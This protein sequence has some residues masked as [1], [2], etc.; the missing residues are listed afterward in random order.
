MIAMLFG[1]RGIARFKLARQLSLKLGWLLLLYSF[2]PLSILPAKE[3]DGTWHT[4]GSAVLGSQPTEAGTVIATVTFPGSAQLY[5]EPERSS[6]RPERDAFEASRFELE[7]RVIS[8]DSEPVRAWLYFKNKEGLWYQT[9]EEY[10]LIPGDWQRLSARLDRTGAVWRAV[11]HPA[12]FDAMAAVNFF[13]GG[14][15]VYGESE[16]TFTLE[17]RQAERLGQRAKG[18]LALVD[19]RFP[20][21]GKVNAEFRGRFQLAREF[22][23]P[24]DPD[25]VV[26]NF[27][28]RPPKGDPIIR[29]AFYSHNYERKLHHTRELVEPVG[30]GFW[31]VRFTPKQVGNYQFRAVIE[32]R[33]HSEKVSCSWHNYIS[34]SSECLGQV[35][36][37]KDGCFFERSTGE[38]FFPVGL[39]LHTNT[40]RRSESC[41]KLGRLADRGTFDYDEYLDACGRNGINAVEVWMA[42]WT[43]ALEHNSIHAGHGGVGRYNLEAAW[44]L[45]QVFERAD[46]NGVLIN[47][48]IDNHGRIAQKVDPEWQENPINSTT[49]YARANG[50][51]L[52]DPAEFFRNELAIKNDRKRARYIAA[53][54]G[55]AP[56]LMAIELWS[57]VDLTESFSE[58]YNDGSVLSWTEGASAYLR[59]WSRPELPVSIHFCNN[60]TLLLRYIEIYD[61]P[62]ITHL[63]GD[64]YRKPTVHFIDHMCNYEETMQNPKPQLVTEYGGSSPGNTEQRLISDIHTGLWCSLASRIAGTPFLW[65]HDFVHLGN[66]YQHYAGFAKYL[67]G[68][69]L[70]DS[71]KVY[72]S[73][74]VTLPDNPRKHEARVLSMPKAAYGWVFDRE[75]MYEYPEKP[76]S[77]PEVP[78]GELTLDG[79]NLENGVYRLRWFTTL[80]GEEL[81]GSSEVVVEADKPLKLTIPKFRL[82]LAF[83]LEKAG[84]K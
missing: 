16:R 49:P 65:W 77:I 26:V 19:V 9:I 51:F 5:L 46:Q 2:I 70:R 10:E 1:V 52:A 71:L 78:S 20:E 55:D 35:Q 50:G 37:A 6:Y 25:E 76:E 22:F 59:E 67:R 21:E 80:D 38:F 74:E 83:K 45:D 36:V 58:R 72:L 79:H 62:S 53:R 18:K 29:P 43:F 75:V 69:D 44:K 48:V 64:A 60:H 84:S 31:E 14:I 4:D 23:N 47:L 15:S 27:E 34:H 57:E 81:Q 33:I 28:I 24:F 56:N 61:P 39:N 32:D 82:D 7:V 41:F 63:A 17:V 11:G 3:L 40:D 13:A 42:G 30:R 73:P 8:E 68:I 12:E 66:H 54:W